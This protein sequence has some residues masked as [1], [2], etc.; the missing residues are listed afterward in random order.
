MRLAGGER[1]VSNS[2]K[3]PGCGRDCWEI[4]RALC[5]TGHGGHGEVGMALEREVGTSSSADDA[6]SAG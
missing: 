2:G 4:V 1:S 3:Q 5:V 6:P